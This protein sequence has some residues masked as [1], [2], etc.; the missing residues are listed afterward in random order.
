MKL[1]PKE[2]RKTFTY[3]GYEYTS[4]GVFKVKSFRKQTEQLYGNGINTT[5]LGYSWDDFYE[6]AKK[7]NAGKADIFMF[8]GQLVIPAGTY[9]FNMN[10]QYAVYDEP[11]ITTISK[12]HEISR[13]KP[14]WLIKK[15]PFAAHYTNYC[16]QEF[17]SYYFNTGTEEKYIANLIVSLGEDISET[18]CKRKQ[19]AG[20]IWNLRQ[21]NFKFLT[22]NGN[23]DDPL[24]F[25]SWVSDNGYSFCAPDTLL[26]ESI[27]EDY[28][29]FVGKLNETGDL[30]YY[31]IYDKE[32]L[33]T[34][35]TNLLQLI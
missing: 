2:K 34:I 17:T 19:L 24:E 10:P 20:K 6:T 18:M 5:P 9:I 11:E 3:L 13:L 35:R 16:L 4:Y 23:M 14:V 7:H 22:V 15:E 28:A 33:I 29:S 32:L 30:F 21:H 8:K 12:S 26:Q 1:I 25:I 31:R 27:N